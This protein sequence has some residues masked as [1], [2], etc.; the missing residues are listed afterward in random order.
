M[1]IK[2]LSVAALLLA[3]FGSFSV[4]AQ[5]TWVTNDITARQISETPAAFSFTKSPYV[6]VLS[7]GYTKISVYNSDF[8]LVTSIIHTGQ[9]LKYQ[10][11]IGTFSC[12]D[13]DDNSFYADG[14]IVSQTLFNNDEA[15]EYI[16]L[17][18]PSTICDECDEGDYHSFSIVSNGAI[19]QTFNAPTGHSYGSHNF[20]LYKMENKY[21]LFVLMNGGSNGG[22]GAT[23]I[24]RINREDVSSVL[25]PVDT[26]IPM[27]VFPSLARRS[28][29]ITVQLGENSNATEVSVVDAA[30]RVVK[31]VSVEPGQ[32]E[33]VI[34]ASELPRG[35][36][37]VNARNG[38]A[39]SAYKIVVQ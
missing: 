34:P 20:I 12:M 2:I 11:A 31:R 10:S 27:N 17:G 26:E 39:Q 18:N 1:K 6:S 19:L 16:A 4:N 21:Y 25:E 28:Q 5:L 9:H 22:D 14:M 30:G 13:L 36:N 8:Q 37:V 23:Q 24:Y 15:F 33:V 7:D 38:Q 3:M 32:R 35:L 29:P